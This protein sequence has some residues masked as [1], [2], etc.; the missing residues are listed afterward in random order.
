M[1]VQT[2]NLTNATSID[3]GAYSSVARKS[4]GSVW[5]WG[6]NE[7][8]QLGN[9]NRDAQLAP[10]QVAGSL[11]VA[12]GPGQLAAHALNALAVK[13]DGTVVAWGDDYYGQLGD[14]TTTN[15]STPSLVHGPAAD[16]FLDGASQVASGADHSVA[17]RSDVTAADLAPRTPTVSSA[18]AAAPIGRRRYRPRA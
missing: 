10:V 14:T 3:G 5:A 6:W 13:S 7:Y 18:T 17:L 4:D 12:S 16:G 1:P 9:G 15:R 8:G 2:A 11:S